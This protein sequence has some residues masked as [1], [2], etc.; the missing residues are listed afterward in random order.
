MDTYQ[1]THSLAYQLTLLRVNSF[2]PSPTASLNK[3]LTLSP[4]QSQPGPSPGA[5]PVTSR[6]PAGVGPEHRRMR[7]SAAPPASG[8]E[9]WW[10]EEMP[11]QHGPCPPGRH[12][13]DVH[14]MVGRR[15][16]GQAQRG[17]EGAGKH[18]ESMQEKHKHFPHANDIHE[19]SVTRSTSYNSMHNVREQSQRS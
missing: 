9:G 19:C 1:F 12:D 3:R 13:G 8:P 6:A 5:V 18:R 4:S 2:S 16:G 14:G 10:R 7:P 11:A 17:V 15:R